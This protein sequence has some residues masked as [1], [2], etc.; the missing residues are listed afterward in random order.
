LPYFLAVDAGGTKT[1]FVL[2]DDERELA[3]VQVGTIKRMRTDEAAAG[4]NLAE[5]LAK[6]QERAGVRVD[7][8]SQTCIGTAGESV[9][10]VVDWLRSAFGAAVGGRLEIVGDVEVALDAAFQ[11]GRGVLVLAGTGSNVAGRG[12]NGR[13]VTAGGWGP[14]LADQGSGH[15]IGLEAVRRGFLAID[16]ER[17]TELLDVTMAHWK[18]PHLPAL[19]EYANARPAPDYSKLAPLVVDCAARGDAVAAEVLEQAGRDLAGL[20]ELV[21]AR[22]RRMEEAERLPFE[23]PTI[24]FA[25]SILE[26][27]QV[28]RVAL[29]TAL[30]GTYPQIQFK[31]ESVDPVLGALWRAR[32]VMALA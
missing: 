4:R 9:P 24:A 18:L 13:I 29:Q 8:I 32:R 5:A 26:Q 27:I 23:L 2:G 28:V 25:G 12:R 17:A 3:R 14:Q 16:R 21:I 6:L 19:V 10:L 30:L 20:A 15:F 31:P 22:I 1:T 7:R 11:G